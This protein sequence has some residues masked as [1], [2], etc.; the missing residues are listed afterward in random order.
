MIDHQAD[1]SPQVYARVGGVLYLII[2]VAGV[3]GELL[4]RGK[5]VV[6]G[7]ATATANNIMAS[8]L[9]WRIGIAGDLIM[10]ACDVPLMVVFYVLLRL[11]NRELALL[12][13]LFN[14]V[15]TAVLVANKLTLLI[16]LFL[17]GSA[18]YLKV[19]EP[20]QLYTLTYLFIRLHGHGFS[21]GL[22]F[23]GF[24]CLILGYLIFRSGYLPKVLGVLMQIAGLSYLTN[25]FTLLLAPAIADLMFPAILVPAFIAEMSLCLWLIVKGVNVEKWRSRARNGQLSRSPL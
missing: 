18:E 4:V 10:H 19:F 17:L 21:V 8:P 7:D 3:L 14:L 6:A 9:L 25:S 20:R 13:V 22:I 1:A 15:Q 2:I 24:T 16:P 11:V 5:M 12:A 23:F